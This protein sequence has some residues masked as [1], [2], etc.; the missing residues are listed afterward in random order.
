MKGR[1]WVGLKIGKGVKKQ[2][3]GKN[4]GKKK[5]RGNGPDLL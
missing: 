1:G 4:E 2:V 3:K 5:E